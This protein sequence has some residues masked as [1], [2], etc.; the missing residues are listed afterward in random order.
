MGE[1]CVSRKGDG[2]LWG[3]GFH[4]QMNIRRRGWRWRVG[5][6]DGAFLHLGGP[7]LWMNLTWMLSDGGGGGNQSTQKK[8]HKDAVVSVQVRP[9]KF[10]FCRMTLKHDG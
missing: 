7:P 2:G 9:D 1:S 5:P 4:E 6:K 3:I 8:T 10:L